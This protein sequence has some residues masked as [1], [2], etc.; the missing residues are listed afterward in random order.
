MY[1]NF[2]GFAFSL[3]GMYFGAPFVIAWSSASMFSL[4]LV[5][6]PIY[7]ALLA[8]FVLGDP[9]SPWY[10]IDRSSSSYP[11]LFYV[12]LIHFSPIILVSLLAGFP[13]RSC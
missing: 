10:R 11:M 3:A 5:T 8:H 4:S 12:C 1:R 7:S 6:V 2:A 9:I 13:W